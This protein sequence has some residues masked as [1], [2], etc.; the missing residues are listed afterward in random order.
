MVVPG[1]TRRFLLAATPAW[2]ALSVDAARGQT[3]TTTLSFATPVQPLRVFT[4]D[5]P[6]RVVVDLPSGWEGPGVVEPEGLVTRLR[7]GVAGPGVARLVLDLA[8]PAAPTL[9]AQADGFL[10]RLVP[11]SAARFAAAVGWPDAARVPQVGTA[12]PVIVLDPGHGGRDPGAVVAGVRE[13]DI[14]LDFALKL[15]PVLAAAGFRVSLTRSDDRFVSLGERKTHARRLGAVAFL[16]LHADTVARGDASGASVYL[17]A[18]DAS[19]AQTA[20]LAERA[21]AADAGGYGWM[22]AEGRDVAAMLTALASRETQRHAQ[23]LG[24]SLVEALRE[25]VPVLSGNPLRAAAFRVL[26]APDVP[27]ALVELGFLSSAADRRRL[28]D[29]DWQGRAQAAL[30]AGLSAWY[31]RLQT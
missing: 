10:I 23:A 22:G 19:D 17:L 27:S 4:L 9:E 14:T 6:P 11:V 7:H 16:S 21:N 18:A 31:A 26:K 5:A 8:G 1:I 20:A 25:R 30:V 12:L 2:G 13:K 15:A 29:P 3:D 28:A 24:T